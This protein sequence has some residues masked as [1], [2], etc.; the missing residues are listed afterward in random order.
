MHKVFRVGRIHLRGLSQL[1]QSLWRLSH[2]NQ[3]LT[4]KVQRGGSKIGRNI[5]YCDFV[6]MM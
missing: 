3:C 2:A 5:S 4:F 6:K 1:V